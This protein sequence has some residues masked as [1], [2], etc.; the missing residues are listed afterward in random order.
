MKQNLEVTVHNRDDK[1]NLKQKN[2][3]PENNT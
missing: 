1:N 3:P 2:I